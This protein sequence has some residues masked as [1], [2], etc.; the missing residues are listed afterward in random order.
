MSGQIDKSFRPLVK[1]LQ[2]MGYVIQTRGHRGHPK[3]FRPNGTFVA[4]LPTS[5][6]DHRAVRNFRQQLKRA[7]VPI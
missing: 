7:G 6:G 2:A 5:S 1:Q 4:P 3:V